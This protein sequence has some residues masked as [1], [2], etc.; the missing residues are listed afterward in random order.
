MSVGL[1]KVSGARSK[2]ENIPAPLKILE[3]LHS[4]HLLQS[5]GVYMPRN[6][7]AAP[8]DT[9]VDATAYAADLSFLPECLCAGK[10]KYTSFL[11]CDLFEVCYQIVLVLRWTRTRQHCKKWQPAYAGQLCRHNARYNVRYMPDTMCNP[12]PPYGICRQLMFSI[13][14]I[15]MSKY[16]TT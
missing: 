8:A 7:A 2:T 5:M 6:R 4:T 9:D 11:C 12:S 14:S 3:R 16:M 15:I 1:P 10:R 13:I